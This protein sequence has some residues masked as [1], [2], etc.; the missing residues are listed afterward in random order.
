MPTLGGTEPIS[1]FSQS[2]DGACV[3]RMSLGMV[4]AGMVSDMQ[5]CVACIEP[6]FLACTCAFFLFHGMWHRIAHDGI[7]CFGA[8]SLDELGSILVA[9]VRWSLVLYALQSRCDEL[10]G[11]PRKSCRCCPRLLIRLHVLSGTPGTSP[12]SPVWYAVPR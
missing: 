5:R 4:T 7:E 8:P 2:L 6:S 1:S 3:G 12:S 11:I 9:I 10:E